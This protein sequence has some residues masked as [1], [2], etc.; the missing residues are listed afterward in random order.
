MGHFQIVKGGQRH[1]AT[2]ILSIIL[3]GEPVFVDGEEWAY[4][5]GIFGVWRQSFRD[6]VRQEDIFLGVDMSI[7]AFIKWC[8][9]LPEETILQAVFNK[10]LHQDRKRRP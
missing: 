4:R 5:E 10:V 9:K 2:T 6:G 7:G 3:S 1:P 8:E